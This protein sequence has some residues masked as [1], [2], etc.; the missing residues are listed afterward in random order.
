MSMPQ[1]GNLSSLVNYPNTST[2]CGTPPPLLCAVPVVVAAPVAVVE[3]D[4]C[5]NPV[6]NNGFM[7]N[8]YHQ[9]SQKGTWA[10]LLGAIIVIAI[11]AWIVWSGRSYWNSLEKWSWG[12]ND[13]L[14]MILMVIGV[15]L[16]AW[17]A[18]TAFTVIVDSVMKRNMVCVGFG[19][20][21]L[22]I[23]IWAFMIFRRDKEGVF[24]TTGVRTGSYVAVLAAI[25]ALMMLYPMWDCG[26]AV[27]LAMVPLLIWVIAM[28]ALSFNMS[29]NLELVE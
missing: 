16:F 10:F 13:L 29:N 1:S 22:L 19:V 7:T 21:M 26:N 12:N 28:A 25:I 18:A 5:G 14:W 9:M 23:V 24:L 11:V 27:R 2:S 3:L 20:V 6:K 15:L 4:S 8:I 17:A